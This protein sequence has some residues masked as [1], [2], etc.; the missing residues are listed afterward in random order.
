MVDRIKEKIAAV[1]NARDVRAEVEVLNADAPCVSSELIVETAEAV[2]K[3]KGYSY[4]KLP[5]RAYHDTLFMA[6][7]C[8][9]AMIFVPSENGYSHRPEE[10]TSPEEIARGVE[11]LALTMARLTEME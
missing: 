1:G 8:P 7:I 4:K 6:Q 10:Y 9:T 3:E 2:T 11:V 5:S